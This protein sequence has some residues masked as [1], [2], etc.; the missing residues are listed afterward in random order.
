[1]PGG[2]NG[3]GLAEHV[4]E[5]YPTLKILLASG[6]TGKAADGG[7]TE[8]EDRV[9]PKPYTRTELARMI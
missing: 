9:L 6:F 4:R 2:M 5:H 1:M 7:A 8:I 3:F